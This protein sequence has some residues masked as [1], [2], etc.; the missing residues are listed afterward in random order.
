MT[1]LQ[2][3]DSQHHELV[4][5]FNE[6]NIS[7]FSDAREED[8]NKIVEN[9]FERVLDYTH[10]H[11]SDE[12]K[13]MENNG[14][15]PRHIEAH[16]ILHE[17]F[18]QQIQTLWKQREVITRKPEIFIGFLISW[19][20]MHILGVDQSL[21][22]QVKRIESGLTPAQ[23][24]E[25]ESSV[26]D[27]GTQALIKMINNLYKV[28]SMQNA[29][30][31]LVNQKLEERVKQRTEALARVNAELEAF[32]RTDG[33][34]KIANRGYFEDRL[35]QACEECA[36]N[37]R[38][39]GL[40]MIDVDFFKRYNDTYGHLAGDEC[41]KT[42]ASCIRDTVVRHSDLVARYGGEEIAVILPD[43]DAEGVKAA[44]ER[45]LESIRNLGLAHKSSEVAQ[46]VTV[47][48]GG[49]SKVPSSGNQSN[50]LI[51]LADDA[52][53]EAKRQGRNRFVLS[54]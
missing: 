22:R 49:I 21:A 1:G 47:S 16:K 4:D 3:V 37:G 53:Y 33:L 34:L 54:T 14:I 24:Y 15:D 20:G 2:S 52:L 42:V 18:V 9:A 48:I 27:N 31:A 30:L 35:R 19:L 8:K 43:T 36:Q 41:L 44:A 12:E 29:E 6:L 10:Y 38:P 45:I 50:Q 13:L 32:S 51:A 7:L 40:L 11:F 26:H 46:I 25:L 17:Q 23:A 39:L 5:L 28:L